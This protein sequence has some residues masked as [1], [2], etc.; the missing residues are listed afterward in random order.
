MIPNVSKAIIPAAGLGTRLLPATK[1]LPKEMLP[2]AGRPLIQYSLEEAARSGIETVILVVN[3]RKQI[4]REHFQREPRFEQLLESQGQLAEAE[5]LRRLS[6]QVELVFVE[7]PETL[8]L[9]HAIW[10][11]R[12]F[13]KGEHFAVLLPDV[14]FQ[15]ERPVLQQLLLAF[16]RHPGNMIALRRVEPEEVSRGG[17][18]RIGESLDGKRFPLFRISGMVEKPAAE[19][20]PSRFSVAGRYLLEP[21]VLEAIEQ[22]IP[23]AKGEVQLTSALNQLCSGSRVYGLCV[24]GTHHDAGEPF[25]FLRAN[26]EIALSDPKLQPALEAYLRRQQAA[27]LPAHNQ[28]KEPP[29]KR[30]RRLQQ[31]S[32]PPRRRS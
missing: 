22:T 10:C 7:Q 27:G 29:A 8:G 5:A 13:V 21:A 20:A 28:S 2:V 18:V 26:L 30:P 11:A 23:D 15:S 16:E 12:E 17:V 4:I 19:D 6:E 9:G 14:I 31:V 3:S 24:E 25:G 1:T 32:K